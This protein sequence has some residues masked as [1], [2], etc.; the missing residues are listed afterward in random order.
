MN[1]IFIILGAVVILF[2]IFAAVRR[3]VSTAKNEQLL[4]S[5]FEVLEIK[6]LKA[7]DVESELQGAALA[8]ENLFASLHGLLR[9]E[10]HLQEHFSLEF[11]A[12]PETGLRFYVIVP[13]TVVK[14]VEGQIY[15]QYPNSQINIV[16]DYT[17]HVNLENLSYEI[18]TLTLSKEDFFPIKSFRD[19]ESDPLSSITSV[20]SQVEN[21]EEMMV[22]YLIKPIGDVWQDAGHN[23]VNAL[24]EGKKA[25][26]SSLLGTAAKAFTQEAT[27]IAAGVLT[28]WLTYSEGGMEA[29]SKGKDEQVKLTAVEELQVEAI[30]EKLAKMGF[31]TQIRL[32]SAAGSQEVAESKLR[33]LLASFQQFSFTNC[34]FFNTD[35]AVNKAAQW[36]KYKERMFDGDSISILN[37]EEL[38]TVYHLPSG[39]LVTPKI[40]WVYSR[41]TEPP[42]NL[43]TKDCVYIGETVFRSQNARFGISEGDDRLRHMYVIGKSGTGKSTLFENMFSQD[44]QA[45]HGV[46]IL[47]PHGETIEKIL[48]RIPDH[49]IDDVIYF[50][51]SDTER[52]VGL[53]LLQIDDPSQKNLL[54]SGLVSAIKQ[55]FDF[56]WGPRLEYLLNYSV[57]TLL[58]VPGTTMLGITRLLEDANYQKFILHFVKDPVVRRFWETE[59]KD[60]KGNQ[61][62]VTEAVAP[63]QNKVNRFL[64]SSTIRNILG[65]KRST[66]DIWDAMNNGKILLI[67]LSKGKIGADNANL[68]GALLVSRIQFYALQRSRIPYDQRRPFYLYVDEFQNF[69]TGSF[70]EI[71]SESRKYKLGL[72]L[73]HQFTA[74]LPEEMLKAVYGNVGTIAT[75]SLGAPDAKTLALEFAPYFTAEDIISLERFQMYV[76]LMV[77]G[78]T[79]TPFAGRIL[80]PWLKEEQIVPMTG[81]REKV[82]HLS[83][84]KYGTDRNYVE[85]KISRWVDT[86]F[87]KG[88]AIA[89]ENRRGEEG[90]TN[91]N[92]GDPI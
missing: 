29:G 16:S 76:K 48:D 63:I 74:Q 59:Y 24:R 83:R 18:A 6:I 52:P 11:Y 26:N 40:N 75:F 1:I 33:L 65:Q 62:L 30:E 91:L 31:E 85:D 61:R 54:A 19:M 49:R 17:P 86:Q 57:L 78:M 56:S 50:D 41:K 88:M 3:L 37:I 32:I 66:I 7:T 14:Y 72:Y 69:T 25:G 64:A 15:A 20:L 89:L 4:S 28:G 80:L 43:P 9:E 36:Q 60:M 58:E 23:Y 22:Q 71:L 77:N 82:L 5:S 21:N 12:S 44:M 34:N 68:L 81:N 70:E 67:N 73:T 51:P 39:N 84:Q 79:S 45:G 53:N 90:S 2:I 46:G 8:A 10:E 27:S 55:H 35:F 92:E 38:A 13:S 47:D 42:A 87:D